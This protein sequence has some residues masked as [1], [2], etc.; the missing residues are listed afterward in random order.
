MF[1][2]S[3]KNIKNKKIIILINRV[4]FYQ[5]HATVAKVIERYCEVRK[6][7]YQL[8]WIEEGGIQDSL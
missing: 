5:T 2:Y 6:S 1:T 8:F 4:V 3:T 7:P